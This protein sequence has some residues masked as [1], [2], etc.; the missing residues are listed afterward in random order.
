MVS[1]VRGKSLHRRRRR[2]PKGRT[3]PTSGRSLAAWGTDTRRPRSTRCAS[4]HTAGGI[5]AWPDTPPKKHSAGWQQD[6][7]LRQLIERRAVRALWRHF[8]LLQYR[9]ES[10][11]Q[12]NVGWDLE[13]TKS[14]AVLR[15]EV[16]GT[17]GSEV[18][19]EVTPNEYA[20][21]RQKRQDYRLCVVTEALTTRP[22]V[23]VFGW[24]QERGDWYCE[25]DKLAIKEII[26]ARLSV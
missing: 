3:S 1:V 22:A 2:H 7:A 18:S 12:K 20:P 21:I 11:E 14:T 10:V 4:L 16:K 9:L 17:S 8:E 24:S 13:A 15:L 6:V 19:C 26:G 5:A 25:D 23:K